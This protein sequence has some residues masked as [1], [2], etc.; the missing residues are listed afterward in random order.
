MK[1]LITSIAIV[2]T[3]STPAM[4]SRN[5]FAMIGNNLMTKALN[6]TE[7]GDY[8]GAC[9]YFGSAKMAYTDAA[10]KEGMKLAFEW[11]EKVCNR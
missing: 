9:L 3:L 11:E 10:F 5:A 2:A 4:A 8:R 1:K 6:L 7:I